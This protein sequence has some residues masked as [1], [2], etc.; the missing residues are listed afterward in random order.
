MNGNICSV[1]L[2]Q[3]KG[4]SNGDSRRED[5]A[6]SPGR[7]WM[8]ELQVMQKKE[9]EDCMQI[10]RVMATMAHTLTR[11]RS[12]LEDIASALESTR[13]VRDYRPA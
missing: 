6:V 13:R 5:G 12:R 7:A 2:E 4:Q 10:H 1:D 11:K 3:H 9:Q 8:D